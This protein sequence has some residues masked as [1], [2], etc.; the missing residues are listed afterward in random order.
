MSLNLSISAD[1]DNDIDVT[2]MGDVE[3]ETSEQKGKPF[4][5]DVHFDS[6]KSTDIRKGY[7]KD[8]TV[9]FAEGQ[10]D[11]G[12]IFYYCPRFKEGLGVTIGY[13]RTLLRWENNPWFNQDRFNTAHLSINGFSKRLDRWFW[14]GQLDINIDTDHWQSSYMFYNLLLWG[15]YECCNNIGFH[16]GFIAQTGMQMDRVYPILGLDWQISRRWKLN[17]VFPVN[18]SL[19]YMITPRWSVAIAGRTFDSRHR[20]SNK[21]PH[22]KYLVRYQNVGGELAI[23]YDDTVVS[24]NIHAGYTLGGDVRIA[25]PHN[26]HPHHYKLDPSAYTGAEVVVRF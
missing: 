26:H 8:D 21:E 19:E 6:V 5:I 9:Q 14:R 12:L 4:S 22:P 2:D 23:K 7:Y 15:R 16:I 11:L 20:V 1:V 24:A 25:N 13:E 18:V 10:V 3:M 17:L